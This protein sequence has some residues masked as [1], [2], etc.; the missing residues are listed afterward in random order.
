M[1]LV[2]TPRRGHRDVCWQCPACAAQ[3]ERQWG[4][5]DLAL[6]LVGSVSFIGAGVLHLLAPWVWD[7]VAM[8]A[9]VLHLLV[10]ITACAALWRECMLPRFRKRPM[11]STTPSPSFSSPP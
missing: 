7:G 11:P 2:P 1:K 5:V 10:L 8:L 9:L 3:L 6:V 4:R